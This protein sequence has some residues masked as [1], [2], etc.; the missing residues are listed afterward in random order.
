MKLLKE[1]EKKKEAKKMNTETQETL[2][3]IKEIAAQ[4][5]VD[6]EIYRSSKYH[7][8][9]ALHTDTC[10]SIEESDILL[11]EK[12]KSA[13]I[14]DVKTYNQTIYANSMSLVSDYC[15]DTDETA[16]M[17]IVVV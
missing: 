11:S 4:R 12:I 6:I 2:K 3:E 9:D 16:H 15:D 7:F 1:Y 14:I 13:G 8:Y 5:L 10:T 17:M